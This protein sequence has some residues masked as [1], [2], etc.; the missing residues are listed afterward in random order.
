VLSKNP[1]M[2]GLECSWNKGA[3]ELGL[4]FNVT[5]IFNTHTHAKV[6]CFVVLFNLLNRWKFFKLLMLISLLQVLFIFLRFCFYA[7]L[8]T[9]NAEWELAGRQTQTLT[10]TR[11]LFHVGDNPYL[12]IC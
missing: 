7:L 11:T 9:T 1:K 5:I 2:P 12:Y 8:L 4:I 6:F 10:D 3:P